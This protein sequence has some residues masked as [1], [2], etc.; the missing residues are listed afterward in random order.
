[1]LGIG[2]KGEN[3]YL[4]K[5]EV[6]AGLIRWPTPGLGPGKSVMET[7]NHTLNR[8]PVASTGSVAR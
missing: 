8:D 2:I 4:R 7:E 1:M 5:Q 3:T 6:Q